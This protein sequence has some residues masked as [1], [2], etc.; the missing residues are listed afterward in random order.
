M[1]QRVNK[2]T[3][4]IIRHEL[5]MLEEE[6]AIKVLAF[7]SDGDSNTANLAYADVVVA[8]GLGLGAVQNLQLLKDLA[9][10]LG[11]A[12]ASPKGVDAG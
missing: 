6:I 12:A 9:R 1:P 11:F 8:G 2:P 7:F 5:K 4:S 10:T 3:G